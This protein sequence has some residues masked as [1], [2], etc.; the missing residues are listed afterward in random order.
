MAYGYYDDR[1]RYTSLMD[2]IDGGGAGRSGDRFEGG[3]LL[4]LLANELFRPRGYEDRLRQ[5]KNDTG[6]AVATVVD[7]LMRERAAMKE[8]ERQRGLQQD[9]L[10][11]RVAA[12]TPLTDD[13][14][15]E[16]RVRSVLSQME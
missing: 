11:P 5:R 1:P 8:M 10:D 2:M 7:E 13:E 6:R 3:G 9:R 4:S 15:P 16:H 12:V 14:C